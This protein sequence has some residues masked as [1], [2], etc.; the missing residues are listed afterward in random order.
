MQLGSE[1]VVVAAAPI[2]PLTW[3]ILNAMG[4]VLKKKKKGKKIN[5]EE[6]FISHV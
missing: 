6:M 1:V 3:E 5:E 4:T 2:Q